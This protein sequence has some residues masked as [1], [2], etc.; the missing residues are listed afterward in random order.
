MTYPQPPG[1]YEVDHFIPLALGGANDIANLFPE[2]AAPTP[3]FHEKDIVE[4]FL[5]EQV[6]SGHATLAAAQRQISTD[7]LAVYN[8]IPFEDKQRIKQ[9]YGG[10]A[11]E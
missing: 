2:A 4:V 6:C 10:S 1:A 7:W 11:V 5:Q 3:G 8:N 9:K